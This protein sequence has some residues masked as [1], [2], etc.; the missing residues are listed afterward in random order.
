SSAYNMIFGQPLLNDMRAVTSSA[1]LLMKFLTPNEI[2]QV[3]R[4]QNQTQACYVSSTRL[5]IGIEK[6]CNVED[7]RE[8]YG[9]EK[10]VSVETLKKVAFVDGDEAKTTSVENQLTES[11]QMEIQDCLRRNRDIFA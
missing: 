7:C 6:T 1:Y 10:P 3:R 9:L 11:I 5:A 2:G 8:K 4:D